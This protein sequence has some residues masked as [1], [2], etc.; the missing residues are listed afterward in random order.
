MSFFTINRCLE[1]LGT[2]NKHDRQE[3]FRPIQ[4]NVINY[5][6]GDGR[7]YLQWWHRYVEAES[8]GKEIS[9]H[10]VQYHT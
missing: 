1:C 9:G 10:I 2:L 8:V 3:V 7:T 6:G 5:F 4:F